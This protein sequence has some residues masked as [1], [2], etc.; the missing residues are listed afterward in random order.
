M[1]LRR[2][3]GFYTVFGSKLTQIRIKFFPASQPFKW[4]RS[5]RTQ[6]DLTLIR[7][8]A[9]LVRARTALVNPASGLAKSHGERLRG[10]NVRNMNPEKAQG[11]SPELQ[12]ALEPLLNAIESLSERIVEYNERI[13]Q[14]AQ[15]SYP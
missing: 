13:E 9:G 5:A 2:G 8:R 12:T 15:Q 4:H 3:P 1:A 6:A 11:L 7:A 14:L 10:C